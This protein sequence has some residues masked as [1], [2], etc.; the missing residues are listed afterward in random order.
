[1]QPDRLTSTPG[2]VAQHVGDQR[3]PRWSRS[4]LVITVAEPP[5]RSRRTSLASTDAVTMTSLTDVAPGSTSAANAPAGV[6]AS[7][8]VKLTPNRRLSNMAPKSRRPR[9]MNTRNLALPLT[10]PPKP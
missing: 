5:I 1:M 9:L 10:D 2:N 8:A 4:S 6:A 7:A 3:V